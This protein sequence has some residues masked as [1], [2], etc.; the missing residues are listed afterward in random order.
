MQSRLSPLLTPMQRQ[1]LAVTML[2]DVLSALA[3]KLSA[4]G[5][6][7]IIGYAHDDKSLARKR[8][9]AAASYLLQRVSVHVSI[10]VVTSSNVGKVML[11]TTKL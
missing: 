5:S 2:E 8:A 6:V 4:G 10:K 3:K 11:V 1:A 7:T 9:E